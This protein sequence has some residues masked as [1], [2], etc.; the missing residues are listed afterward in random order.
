MRTGLPG[1]LRDGRGRRPDRGGANRRATRPAALRR[2]R[3]RIPFLEQDDQQGESS[4]RSRQHEQ[5]RAEGEPAPGPSS[6]TETRA[7]GNERGVASSVEARRPTCPA[8]RGTACTSQIRTYGEHLSERD[9]RDEGGRA[10]AQQL[11]GGARAL[12]PDPAE[13]D[14]LEQRG[15]R[16]REAGPGCVQ[17]LRAVPGRI[18]TPAPKRWCAWW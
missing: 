4:T 17:V 3:Q 8:T 16:G 13:H 14:Q 1:P 9:E 15:E 10:P 11:L 12:Q 7:T 18:S 6:E 2:S 5:R